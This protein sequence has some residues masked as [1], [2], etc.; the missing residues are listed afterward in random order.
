MLSYAKE[1]DLE[2]LMQEGFCIVDFY[3]DTCGPC[4]MLAPV[5]EKLESELPFIHVIKVNISTY[6]AYAQQFEINAVPTILFLNEGELKERTLGFM[7]E[8][9]LREKISEYLYG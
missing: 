2:E 3:S 7:T 1:N 6:P 5:L 8:T 4:K 9:Q